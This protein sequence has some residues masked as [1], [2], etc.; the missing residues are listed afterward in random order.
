MTI[1]GGIHSFSNLRDVL[2]SVTSAKPPFLFFITL[3]CEIALSK[4]KAVEQ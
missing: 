4:P 3:I 1:T 2:P